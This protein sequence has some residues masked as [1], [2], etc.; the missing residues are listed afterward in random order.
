M[1]KKVPQYL[2]L[3][4]PN[5]SVAINRY[6]IRQPRLQ[7]PFHTH[8]YISQTSKYKLP[9]LLNSI[10]MHSDDLTSIIRNVDNI[11]LSESKK[12]ANLICLIHIRMNALII[13]T[14]QSDLTTSSLT[15]SCVTNIVRSIMDSWN[16]LS[17]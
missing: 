3:F 12:K 5:T 4:L 14:C 16:Y 6:P 7:P 1:H 15:F 8:A 10:K 17:K 9:V 2:S 11:S 13:T